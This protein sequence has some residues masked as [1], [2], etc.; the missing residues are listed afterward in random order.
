MGSVTFL[1]GSDALGDC[2]DISE[3]AFLVS[4]LTDFIVDFLETTLSYLTTTSGTGSSTW[5]SLGSSSLMVSLATEA[6]VRALSLLYRNAFV[7]EL[8]L[9]MVDYLL[10]NLGLVGDL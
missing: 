5:F 1:A 10:T 8:L 7:F 6:P 4:D 3:G 2:F 9:L